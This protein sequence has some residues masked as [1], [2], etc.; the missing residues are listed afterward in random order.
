MVYMFQAALYCEACGQAIREGLTAEGKAPLDADD[1]RTYDSDDFPKGPFEPDESDS[2]EHCDS[3]DECLNAENLTVNPDYPIVIG[4][5]LENPLTE[6]GQKGLIETVNALYTEK[7]I[8]RWSSSVREFWKTCYS[9]IDFG[10]P[11]AK[12]EE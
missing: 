3:G 2:V 4:A 11:F 5:W 7:G 10:D 12:G 1:E 8:N 9:E 6:E